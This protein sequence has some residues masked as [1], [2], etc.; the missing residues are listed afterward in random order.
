MAASGALYNTHVGLP[1][2]IQPSLAGS[3]IKQNNLLL[4]THSALQLAFVQPASSI[5]PNQGLCPHHH[6]R[7]QLAQPCLELNVLNVPNE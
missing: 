2:S 5:K 3:G 4:A 6:T 1:V 7:Q